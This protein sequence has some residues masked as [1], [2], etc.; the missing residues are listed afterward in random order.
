MYGVDRTGVR[1]V[2]SSV[3][4][5]SRKADQ[6]AWYDMYAAA[7]TIPGFLINAF[8]FDNTA[9]P[10]TADEPQQVAIYD[11]VT[12]DPA[13]AWP[14]TEGWVGYP[15]EMYNDPRAPL[16]SGSLR[17]SFRHV[18]SLAKPVGHGELTGVHFVL[19]DGA[20]DAARE[21][22]ASEVLDAGLFYAAS[23]FTHI[24]I[25]SDAETIVMGQRLS[26]PE[27][28]KWLEV[29]ETDSD[30]PLTAYQRTLAKIAPKRPAPEIEQ[31][32]GGS[33]R[34]YSAHLHSRPS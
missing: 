33:Y 28:A 9:M 12:P 23:R 2:L 32:H 8:R 29:F 31:R 16:V 17:G 20:D 15:N 1:F 24:H 18:G 19:S 10:G 3:T 7:L 27:P 21:A 5:V 6:D 34:F 11:I 13:T 30:D 22:W 4:E 25:P 14:D 26:F